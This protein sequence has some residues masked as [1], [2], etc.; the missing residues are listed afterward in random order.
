MY[1]DVEPGSVL[2][3]RCSWASDKESSDV[4]QNKAAEEREILQDYGPPDLDTHPEHP[5]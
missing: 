1:G 5:V 2:G 3:R 4:T